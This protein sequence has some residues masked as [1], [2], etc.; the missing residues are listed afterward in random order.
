MH[1]MG[2][3][4][5][6]FQTRAKDEWDSY[7]RN[8]A[9][10][11]TYHSFAWREVIE[12]AFSKKTYYLCA[13]DTNGKVR[14]LLPLV[15]IR[16]ALVGDFLVSMPY[17]NYGGVLADTAEIEA[18]LS[19]E[20]KAIGK[21]LGCDTLE[22]RN[23]VRVDWP[24]WVL[25]SDKV[26]LTL[27]LPGSSEKLWEILGSKRR[28]QIRR[29]L[30]EQTE[31]MH[32]GAELIS[33][34]YNVFCRNIRDLGTP[35]YPKRFFEVIASVLQTKV[36]IIVIKVGG[37]PVASC[38]LIGHEDAMEIPWAASKRD[39]NRLG[40]NMLLYWEALKYAIENRFT[41][42][43]FGRSSRDS[44]TYHFKRQWGAEEKEIPWV[45]WFQDERDSMPGFASSL[46][47][48]LAVRV[49][50]KIP[51]PIANWLGPKISP[52]LPW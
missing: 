47:M 22:L 12:K 6:I 19:I 43:D 31:I 17:C 9:N 44:G 39:Y 32:G 41:T 42:F 33:E 35:V 1:G 38:F 24:N 7:V 45:Y 30:K 18:Q 40:I 4:I 21:T 46:R 37:L 14:G 23:L 16:C 26:L 49:W 34:F 13:K 3:T 20:A 48:R 15:R 8:H 36:H 29:P 2:S 11:S 25:R 52:S 51:L 28:A 50:S 27:N 10:G 5:N